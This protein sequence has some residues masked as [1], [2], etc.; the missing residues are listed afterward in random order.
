[1]YDTYSSHQK[2][3]PLNSV[4]PL[5]NFLSNGI[6]FCDLYFV[7]KNVSTDERSSGIMNIGGF[8]SLFWWS[9]DYSFSSSVK[10][11]THISSLVSHWFQIP[12]LLCCSKDTRL[13]FLSLWTRLF[14]FSP[15]LWVF[16]CLW[17]KDVDPH[18][19]DGH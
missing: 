15:L 19:S 9:F 11:W 6:Q 4:K 2:G 12:V 17:C 8:S 5:F 14:R 10:L 13:M 18:H 7:Y 16:F 3:N 1:M